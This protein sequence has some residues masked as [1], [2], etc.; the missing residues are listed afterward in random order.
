MAFLT[1]TINGT[2]CGPLLHKLGLSD[3]TE[4]RKNILKTAEEAIRRR[5]LDDFLHLMTDPRYFFVDFALVTHHCPRLANLT[6]GE[7]EQ[8]IDLN[9][10]TTHPQT[11]KAPNLTH[12]LPYVPDSQHLRWAIEKAQRQM[13]ME[14]PA[15][16]SQKGSFMDLVALGEEAEAEGAES[17]GAEANP[18]LVIDVRLMFIELLRAAYQGQIRDGELDPR[19]F[20][21]YLAFALVQSLD[22]AYE[23]AQAGKPLEDW[24][25]SS[26][27][28]STDVLARAEIFVSKLYGSCC[29]KGK[30]DPMERVEALRDT[31]PLQHHMLRFDVM[32]AFAF[33]DAHQEAQDRLQDEFGETAGDAAPAFVTVMGESRAQVQKAQ[34]VLRRKNK[35]KLRQVISHHLCMILQNKTARYIKLLLDSGVLMQRE[36]RHLLEETDHKLSEIRQCQQVTHVGSI[37]L[38][39]EPAEQ[40]GM[41][42]RRVRKRERQN[43]IL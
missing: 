18:G 30:G 11:Y 43:S 19:E 37:H 13:F 41:K 20:N 14:A 33:I 6:A 28:V 10:S 42:P 38:Q 4:S 25:A 34:D 31:K 1:L 26:A 36:A 16:G 15:M 39:D 7:L 3:S 9:K 5:I 12:V 24:N 2:S 8:A 40:E 35:K 22:F 23:Q 17:D 32:R 29:G 21:G 27:L